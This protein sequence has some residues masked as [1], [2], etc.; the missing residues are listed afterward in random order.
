VS[1]PQLLFYALAGLALFSAVMMVVLSRNVVAGTMS[2]V[3][4]MICL[5]GIFVLLGAEFLGAI[6]II[7]YAGAIMVLLL[8]VVMLLNL[9]GDA[10][11]PIT[12]ARGGMKLLACAV[13]VTVAALFARS[14]P[15]GEA[16]AQDAA[17][18]TLSMGQSRA[19][20][21]VLFT[22]F[23]LPLEVTGLLL[24]AAIVGAVIIAKRRID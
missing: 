19:V 3:V 9:E 10:F 14:L 2:L 18:L 8:F 15:V 21:R 17:A 11:T 24:L 20:G 7:V 5:S 6:Q 12:R 16:P 4:T 1:T 23:V 13:V 22:D